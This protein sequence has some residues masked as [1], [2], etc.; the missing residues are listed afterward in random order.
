MNGGEKVSWLFRPRRRNWR[1]Y[2][3]AYVDGELQGA[4]LAWFEAQLVEAPDAAQAVELER[5][6]SRLVAT[7]LPETPAPRSFAI[8]PEMAASAGPVAPARPA[9]DSARLFGRLTVGASIAAAVALAFVTVIDLSGR[10]SGGD[11][12]AATM[13]APESLSATAAEDARAGGSAPGADDTGLSDRDDLA[14]DDGGATGTQGAGGHPD[15]T[16]ATEIRLEDD[17]DDRTTGGWRAVQVILG[18]VLVA[19]FG[20][21]LVNRWTRER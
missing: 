13:A 6:T 5:A 9:V 12:D 18:F 3:S 8:T 15:E 20:G 19:S 21:Y 7:A 11:D 16:G 14:P 1:D 4:D 10:E 2:V 17:G